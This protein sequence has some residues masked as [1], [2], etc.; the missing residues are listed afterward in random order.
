MKWIKEFQKIHFVS[1]FHFQS[2]R[3]NCKIKDLGFQM[4]F[5]QKEAKFCKTIIYEMNQ[6]ISKIHFVSDFYFQS[7]GHDCKIRDGFFFFYFYIYILSVCLSNFQWDETWLCM[8]WLGT[9]YLWTFQL[10]VLWNYEPPWK[11]R[12]CH[13]H[14]SSIGIEVEIC[15]FGDSWIDSWLGFLFLCAR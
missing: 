3:H 5:W 1:D 4:K 13:S 7:K 2:K 6:R 9:F 11:I 12:Y 8:K 15:S 14:V 10:S